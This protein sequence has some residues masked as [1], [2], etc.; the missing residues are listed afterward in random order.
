MGKRLHSG[1]ETASPHT[2]VHIG[3]VPKTHLPNGNSSTIPPGPHGQY[4]QFQ[5][6]PKIPIKPTFAVEFHPKPFLNFDHSLT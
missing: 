4:S 1:A 3:T 6:S 5:T 2:I